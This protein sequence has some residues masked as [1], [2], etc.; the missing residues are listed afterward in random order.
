MAG[1]FAKISGHGAVLD[2]AVLDRITAN[3]RPKARKSV[4]KFGTQIAS[5]SA[6]NAPVGTPESTGIPGYI[7][8]SLRNSITSESKMT[9]DMTFTVSDGVEYGIYNEFGTSKMGS[10]PF[11]RPAIEKWAAKFQAAFAELFK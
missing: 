7:G 10:H 11:M 1:S 2:T 5:Q 3:M 8:G 9:G 4:L 6:Q